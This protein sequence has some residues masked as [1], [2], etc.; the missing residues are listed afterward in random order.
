MNDTKTEVS[1]TTNT[2]EELRMKM[3]LSRPKMLEL[4]G[5]KPG[6]FALLTAEDNQIDKAFLVRAQMLKQHYDVWCREVL[7]KLDNH[8][9]KGQESVTA[10]DVQAALGLRDLHVSQLRTRG[11]LKAEKQHGYEYYY[12]VAG[13]K[14]LLITNSLS[15]EEDNRYRG[16]LS[17]GFLRWLGQQEDGYDFAPAGR[18]N[19]VAIPAPTRPEKTLQL[20]SV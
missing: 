20:A 9:A 12:P 14:D 18:G 2:V 7:A 11:I 1:M 15:G 6:R 10:A 16:P 5:A 17:Y 8:L 4:I 3:G 19:P 13:L